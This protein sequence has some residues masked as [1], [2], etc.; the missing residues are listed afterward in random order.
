MLT[1]ERSQA[2]RGQLQWT[3]E[4]LALEAGV[5]VQTVI[6]FELEQGAIAPAIIAALTGALE[7]AGVDWAALDSGGRL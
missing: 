3:R 2:A 5:G 7:A 1:P 6:E 4:R